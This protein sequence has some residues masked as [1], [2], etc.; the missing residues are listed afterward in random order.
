M[1]LWEWKQEGLVS[2]EG[3]NPVRGTNLKQMQGSV[4]SECEADYRQT[5]RNQT[6]P[7]LCGVG[8][9]KRQQV[10]V[11]WQQSRCDLLNGRGTS[12]WARIQAL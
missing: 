1:R 11:Y 5:E 8:R 3:A 6:E 9:D 2:R 12:V 10:P 7:L 4:G